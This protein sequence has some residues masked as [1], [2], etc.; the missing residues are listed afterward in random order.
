[1][2]DLHRHITWLFFLTLLPFVHGQDANYIQ[3]TTKD[4]L[5]TNYVYGV[6]EDEDGYIW[7]YT[8]NGLAK[9]DGYEFE[10]YTVENG[11]P[12]N[13][14][15]YAEC[16]PD[17]KIWLYVYKNRPAYLYQDSIHIIY[18][19]RCALSGI[20]EGMAIYGCSGG[21]IGYKDSLYH[22]NI[23]EI[24]AELLQ[25]YPEVFTPVDWTKWR[26]IS[27]VYSVLPDGSKQWYAANGYRRS[28]SA[29]YFYFYKKGLLVWKDS[30]GQWQEMKITASPSSE[31]HNFRQVPN[32]NEFLISL[33]DGDLFWL[34]PD[35]KSYTHLSMQQFG[36]SPKAHI[37]ITLQD[38][39]FW[40]DSD[41]GALSFDY[42]GTLIDVVKP[43]EL[44]EQYFLH[45]IYKDS[46]G[47]LWI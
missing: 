11:L 16:S 43:K 37:D 18:D 40:L 41:A 6:V 17:G 38:D 30:L 34:R 12:G 5:P 20:W 46:N 2:T 15:P 25:K 28:Y 9:F 1:M 31:A 29:N 21:Y 10:H 4:G 44:I 24:S 23:N 32:T 47:N 3:Y 14:I 45:R 42:S 7:A 33:Q 19:G 35:T 36:I 39:F 22:L 13:D 26:S 27:S 8:E